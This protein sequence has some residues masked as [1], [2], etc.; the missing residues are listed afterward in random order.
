MQTVRWS[1]TKKKVKMMKAAMFLMGV[2]MGKITMEYN[3]NNVY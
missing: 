3:N 2:V 1:M